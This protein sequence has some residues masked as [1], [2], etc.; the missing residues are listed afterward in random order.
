ML[1]V[2]AYGCEYED[3]RLKLNNSATDTLH[4]AFAKDTE[5]SYPETLTLNESA[6]K[7]TYTR[8]VLFQTT[9]N[10]TM[11]GKNYWP[12]LVQRSE[13]AKLHLYVIK[14]D[15]FRANDWETICAKKLYKRVDYSL[16]QLEKLNWVIDL[17]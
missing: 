2:F 7:A 16:P 4:I 17:N 15:V 13:K 6:N 14:D 11:R 9:E 12:D 10:I 5:L 1:L 3:T 8:N